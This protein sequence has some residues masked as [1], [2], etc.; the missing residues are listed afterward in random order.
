MLS[1]LLGWIISSSAQAA[2]FDQIT[3]SKK[4]ISVSFKEAQGWCQKS[5]VLEVGDQLYPLEDDKI[6][7]EHLEFDRPYRL[8]LIDLDTGARSSSVEFTRITEQ[9][10]FYYR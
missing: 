1:I 10:T 2:A 9:G 5:C 8:T 7:V 4:H 3:L 6:N